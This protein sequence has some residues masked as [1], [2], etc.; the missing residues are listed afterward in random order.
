ML[1]LVNFGGDGGGGEAKEIKLA[2]GRADLGNINLTHLCK[3][4][5]VHT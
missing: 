1:K 4:I 2:G 5:P 3:Y